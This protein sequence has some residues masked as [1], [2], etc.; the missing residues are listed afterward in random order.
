MSLQRMKAE[1]ATADVLAILESNG[2]SDTSETFDSNS[3]QDTP[4]EYKVGNEASKEDEVSVNSKERKCES[5]EISALELDFSPAH[6]R[7]LSWKGR[8]D[9]PRLLEKYKDPSLRRHSSFVSTS[10]SQ[11][12]H[13]GKSCRKIRCEGSRSVQF[14]IFML[15]LTI[16]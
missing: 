7:S 1:K 8:K 16:S 13:E 6:G 15:N 11:K 9:S 10:S 4:C 14:T 12:H 5:E 3:D 2:L